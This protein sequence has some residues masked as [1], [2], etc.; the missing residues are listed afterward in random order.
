MTRFLDAHRDRFA[1]AE[2][3]RV[4]GWNASTYYAYKKRQ[5][6]NRAL[7]DADLAEDITR[8]YAHNYQVYG[9]RKVWV[10]LRRQ[11]VA[12]ARCTVARL[13][14]ELG[15]TGVRRGRT[16][17]RTTTPDAHAARALPDL[18]DRQF[19]ANRPNQLWT[20]DLTYVP[21]QRGGF[22]YTALITDVY[23]RMIVGWAVSTSLATDLPL[24]AL[25]MALWRRRSHDLSGLIHHSDRGTQY[26]SL[27]Y[28]DRLDLERIAASVGSVGDSYDNALIESAIGLYKTEL[29]D[30][31]RPWHTT[32]D[33]ELATLEY[34]NWFNHERIH[35]AIGDRP[36]IEH[37][38]AYRTPTPPAL[39]ES[40][41]Q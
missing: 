16:P 5:P 26:T 35:T 18:V 39:A 36:P 6:S 24:A 32:L 27:R 34:T 17:V 10:T 31:H 12:V 8:V 30:Q 29:I 23:S 41:T 28:A 7:R 14:R 2:M 1:V 40:I 9:A 38:A 3:C 11:G 20:A 33:V 22:C 21:L 15:M 4:L 25:E 19:T 13:M 37:E